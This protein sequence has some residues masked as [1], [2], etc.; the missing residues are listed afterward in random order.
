MRRSIPI[1]VSV[2]MLLATMACTREDGGG[3][4]SLET[5]QHQLGSTCR[6]TVQGT[7]NVDDI[8]WSRG[9]LDDASFRDVTV[10]SPEP[11]RVSGSVHPLRNVRVTILRKRSTTGFISFGR[12][13]TDSHGAFSL[14]QSANCAA[15]KFRIEL[16]FDNGDLTVR[17]AAG[18]QHV[19]RIAQSPSFI[20]SSVGHYN[21]AFTF[22]RAA[23]LSNVHTLNQ[24]R[25][26]NIYWGAKRL[27]DNFKARGLPYR[28]KLHVRYP[29]ASLCSPGCALPGD[30]VMIRERW[31]SPTWPTVSGPTLVDEDHRK[32]Q[33]IHELLHHWHYFQVDGP[34]SMAASGLPHGC[35]EATLTAFAEGFTQWAAEQLSG[36]LFGKRYDDAPLNRHELNDVCGVDDW[37]SVTHSEIGITSMLRLLQLNMY[38]RYDFGTLSTAPGADKFIRYRAPGRFELARECPNPNLSVYQIMAAFLPISA[39]GVTPRLT[40]TQGINAFLDR[41]QALYPLR[42]PSDVRGHFESLITPAPTVDRPADELCVPI[43]RLP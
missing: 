32:L 11:G 35:W 31:F 41:L 28:Q 27:V 16:S 39:A 17:G 26:A 29:A 14:T 15:S 10:P 18:V 9:S 43:V 36:E 37:A 13:W 23:M 38:H 4:T 20:P 2:L 42:F 34:I 19:I 1:I 24:W 3:E 21:V 33:V 25:A 30:A 40:G 6:W 7:I 5:S 22:N 12:V 8:I